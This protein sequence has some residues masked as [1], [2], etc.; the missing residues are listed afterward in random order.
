MNAPPCCLCNYCCTTRVER[1]ERGLAPA[2][3]HSTLAWNVPLNPGSNAV[4]MHVCRQHPLDVGL[5]QATVMAWLGVLNAPDGA[6][7][8]W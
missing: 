2:S 5:R 3:P 8:P 1:M 7:I 4:L 6:A